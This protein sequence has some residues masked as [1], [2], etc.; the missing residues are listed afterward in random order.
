M[1]NTRSHPHRAERR[2]S[3]L[4]LVAILSALFGAGVQ[5]T[6]TSLS[7]VSNSEEI[8]RSGF[9]VKKNALAVIAARQ[10]ATIHGLESALTLLTQEKVARRG[11][12][13]QSR[14]VDDGPTEEKV[15]VTKIKNQREEECEY[16]FGAGLVAQYRKSKETWCQG[17]E[18]NLEC[19]SKRL[20]YNPG[21]TGI[22][23]VGKNI[24]IDFAKVHGERQTKKQARGANSYL[25]FTDSA[26][27]ADC[28]R[29]KHWNS[30][31]LMKH[32]SAQLRNFPAAA[33]K[34]YDEDRKGTTY[35]MARDE[36]CEN[37]FHSTA[38]F[39][40]AFLVGQVLNLDWH[41]V[42]LLL[43][44]RHPDGPF[45]DLIQRSYSKKQQIYRPQN[46]GSKK[47]RFEHL[48]FHLES[49]ASIIF[50]KVA[51]PK[52]IMRCFRSSLWLGYKDHILASFGLLHIQPPNNPK[53][54]L[55]VRRRT[56][57]KNVGRVFADEKQLTS[58]LNKGQAMQFEVIDFGSISFAQQLEKVR[59]TN[60]LIGAHGAGL[61]HTIFLAEEAILLEIHPSYRLDRHF[62]LAARMA[63]KIYLPMR[64]MQPV[65]CSGTSDAIPIDSKQFESVL[66]A[67]LRIARAFDDGIAECGLSCDLRLLALDPGASVPPGTKPLTTR[68]PC[69]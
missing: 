43:W 40:N 7:A 52:G 60:I 21:K 25:T 24:V 31:I 17:L 6:F 20:E 8:G 59:R 37:M 54:L 51:G 2:I 56:P 66:D 28:K 38:D 1:V 35:L 36:D 69:R 48:I 32:M 11:E 39:L 41:Q 16:N 19:Y 50:P 30:G 9:D 47:V 62:R 45:F 4:V 15:D 33:Y 29:T 26:T 65:S 22:F 64:S 18:A 12:K 13:R 49:P 10:N 27:S 58:V 3:T 46:F 68:F 44:D 53:I 67:A 55:S 5:R 34:N 23:C 14:Y 61:M 57:A 42:H 63:G